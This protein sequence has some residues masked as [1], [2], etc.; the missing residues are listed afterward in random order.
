MSPPAPLAVAAPAAP[1]VP[2]PT[3]FELTDGSFET[4]RIQPDLKGTVGE[5]AR[6]E[7]VALALLVSSSG[8]AMPAGGGV[9]PLT[10][11]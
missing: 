10:P 4:V 6:P 8:A 9:G 3:L 1:V 11:C 7:H 5:G 2:H